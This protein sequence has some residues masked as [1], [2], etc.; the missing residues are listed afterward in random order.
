MYRKNTSQIACIAFALTSLYSCQSLGWQCIGQ[1]KDFEMLSLVSINTEF[2]AS[3]FF[4]SSFHRPEIIFQL[5]HHHRR[6]APSTIHHWYNQFLQ[7]SL[8]WHIL[9]YMNSRTLTTNYRRKDMI[10]NE[11]EPTEKKTNNNYFLS[12]ISKVTSIA[13][14]IEKKRT[15]NNQ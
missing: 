15:I 2:C 10:R 4:D 12:A 3:S 1:T 8:L 14:P 7:A 5:L 13:A 6:L 11:G 9:D